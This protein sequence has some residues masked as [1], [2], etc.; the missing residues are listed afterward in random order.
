[1]RCSMQWRDN[2]SIPETLAALQFHP[3]LQGVGFIEPG[4]ANDP[5][6][7]PSLDDLS[8]LAPLAMAFLSVDGSDGGY[9]GLKQQLRQWAKSDPMDTLLATVIG[10]GLAFYAAEHEKNAA[11]QTPWDAILYVATSL[12]VGYDNLFPTTSLG[13]MIATA[14]HTFGPAFA[15]AA[16][17][18]P[19]AE[20]RAAADE[21]R[22]KADD[23]AAVNRAILARLE[24]IVRLLEAKP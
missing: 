17:E 8:A 11:C 5:S 2:H 16:L 14:V 1:M 18:P 21:A 15:N 10:G 6:S 7:S 12:S 3:Y 20:V 19:A 9:A 13:H 4:S 23:A 22:V 24:D